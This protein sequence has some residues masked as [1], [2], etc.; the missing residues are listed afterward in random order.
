MIKYCNDIGTLMSRFNTD[1]EKY[2]TDISFQYSCNM[3]IIQIGE[4]VDRL[5]DETKES[6]SNIPWLAIRGMRNLHEHDYENVDME[7]VW[8]TLLEDIPMLK[9]N[10]EALLYQK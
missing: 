10:L 1:F 9:Q 8:N 3:C 7:I 6:S 5:S 2:K 4:P